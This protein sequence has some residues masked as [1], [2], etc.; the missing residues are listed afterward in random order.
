M[1]NTPE[2]RDSETQLDRTHRALAALDGILRTIRQALP[3]APVLNSIEDDLRRM[4]ALLEAEED[5]EVASERTASLLRLLEEVRNLEAA[6]GTAGLLPP[7]EAAVEAI[8]EEDEG[9]GEGEVN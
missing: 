2:H 3:P 5:R 9:K 1:T 8:E 6:F 7:A 4:P